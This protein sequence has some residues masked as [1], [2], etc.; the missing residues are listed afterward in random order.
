MV[1][2][3][4]SALLVEEAVPAQMFHPLDS[5]ASTVMCGGSSAEGSSGRQVSSLL[6]AAQEPWH[7]SHVP[8]V[9]RSQVLLQVFIA[10]QV[11]KVKVTT[12][13]CLVSWGPSYQQHC[14]G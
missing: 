14:V 1:A 4:H 3:F 7:S 6:S 8:P 11:M 10:L 2:G 9:H 5:S 12:R 13:R